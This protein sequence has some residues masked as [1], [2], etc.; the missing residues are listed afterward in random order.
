MWGGNQ[1]IS[2]A[3]ALVFHQSNSSQTN[4]RSVHFEPTGDRLN[5]I[6][7]LVAFGICP[8]AP[9]SAHRQ[10]ITKV[11]VIRFSFVFLFIFQFVCLYV[12]YIW[13]LVFFGICSR[14]ASA[15][16]QGNPVGIGKF[17]F[18]CI[19]SHLHPLVCLTV[20]FAQ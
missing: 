11:F 1:C 3:S 13:N 2:T 14:L 18:I 17:I 8:Q 15:H 20:N 7:Y 9:A 5:V 12:Q 10:A 6:W 16:R 4:D 19:C